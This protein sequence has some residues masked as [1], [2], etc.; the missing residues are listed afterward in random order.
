MKG[1]LFKDQYDVTVIGAG[2]GGLTAAALLSKAGFSVCVLE[3][4]P[5]VGGYLAG[6]RRRDFIFDTAIHWLNQYNAQGIVTKL[7]DAIGNDHPI[8]IS[9]KHTRRYK[10]GGF[11]YLLTNNPDELRDQWI[12]EFPQDEKGIRKFFRSAR[13][14]GDSLNKLSSIFRSEETM[15]TWEKI[16]GKLK[17][18]GVIAPFI[19]FITYSGEKGLKKGLNKYFEQAALGA[20]RLYYFEIKD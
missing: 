19:P 1:K 15:T 4:E 2:I 13:K 14:I 11:D 20:A 18:F 10:G 12:K 7:F 5:H 17:L 16:A 3:K 8:A 6:F 9:L